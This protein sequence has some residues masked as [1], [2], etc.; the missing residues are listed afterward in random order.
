MGNQE[1]TPLIYDGVMY[2]PNGGDYVQAFDAEVGHAALG[3]PPVPRRRARRHESQPRDLGHDADRRRRRQRDVRD[4]RAH[5]QARVGDTGARSDAARARELGPDHRERQG[6]HGP[7]VPAAGDARVVRHHGARCGDGQGALAHAHD[8]A[9]G[10]ARRRELGRR[11][12]GAA[13]ARRHV[14][15]AE[16][17]RRSSTASTSAR[18]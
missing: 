16:L 14:D 15:G 11:A 4:R 6:H 1:S 7:A 8:S 2:V 12:D 3:V 17:R 5:G 13:L 9:Q 18:R 10:R